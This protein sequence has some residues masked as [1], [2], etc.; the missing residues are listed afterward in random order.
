MIALLIVLL[1][2]LGDAE[3]AYDDGRYGE[4]YTLFSAAVE[5]EPQ[6]PLLYN[7]GNCAYRLDRHAEAVLLYRRAQRHLPRDRTLAFNLRLAEEQCGVRDR[8][9]L[10][11]GAAALALVDSFHFNELLWIVFLLECIGLSGLVLLWRRPAVR[12]ALALIVVIAL[13]AGARLVQTRW[14]PGPPDGVVLDRRIELRSEPHEE[15]PVT[16][17]LGAGETVRI[18]AMSDRWA[19]VEHGNSGGWTERDGVGVVTF[20]AEALHRD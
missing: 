3:R 9:A 7:L 8:D 20:S 1:A 15:F 17:E 18:K 4:A 5:V 19:L 10:S 16:A 12:N 11:F 6:G 13:L 14:F 2:S